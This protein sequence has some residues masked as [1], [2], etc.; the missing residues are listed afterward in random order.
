MEKQH[1]ALWLEHYPDQKQSAILFDLVAKDNK[2]ARSITGFVDRKDLQAAKHLSQ[3]SV[4]AFAELNDLLS[5]GT[6]LIALQ[7]SNDEEIL[8]KHQNANTPYSI[9]QMSDGERNA[10]MLGAAVLTAEAGTVLLIDE[11][12]RHL[13]RSII[14]PFLAAVLASRDD[15]TLIISTHDL[16]LPATNPQASVLM[17]RSCDW[18]GD[19]AKAW[20]VQLLESDAQMPE[21]LRRAILGSRRKILFIEGAESSLDLPIYNALF[22]DISVMAR[23]TGT[24]VQKAVDGIRG[25]HDLHHIDAFGLIDGDGRTPESVH[26]LRARGI[27]ALDLYSAESLYYCSDALDAVAHRQAGTL[28]REPSVLRES[29]LQAA[30]ARIRHQ[31]GRSA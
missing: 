31:L 11:P 20:D 5:L 24:N 2:R 6:L 18:Q 17:V 27:F 3:E 14:V 15:C 9:A 10:T 7:N 22:P 16:A 26:D 13:H 21:D 29:A 12:E 8:A 4:S 30:L 19:R 25:S 23:G 1:D 28:G